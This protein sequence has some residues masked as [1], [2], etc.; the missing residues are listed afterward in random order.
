M[1]AV[2]AD[3]AP[4]VTVRGLDF[5]YASE[6]LLENIQLE[7]P[8]GRIS[9]II[10]PTA[11]GKTTLLQLITGQLRP[12]RGTVLFGGTD[13]HQLRRGELYDLRKRIG[14]QLQRNALLTD[15]SVFD[16]VAFPLREHTP[17][18]ERLIRDIVLMKLEAVGLRGARDQMPAQLSGGMLRRVALARAVA[19]D[20]ELVI[21][22]E[23]FAGQD[24]ITLGVLMR[25]VRTLNDAL[26]LTTIL[27]SHSVDEV[28][29]ICDYVYVISDRRIVAHGTPATVRESASSHVQ[30]F[31]TGAAQGPTAFD[32]PA[33]SMQRDFLRIP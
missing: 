1:T 33:D 15:I 29:A 30:Q 24:P 18:P 23:P 6:L 28:L 12:R 9:A 11:C 8:R 27:V 5:G 31:L 7:I 17:L 16:N 14:M 22:D 19:L 13:V 21:Y 25:L 32:F 3:G 2:M 10:G 20:P 4:L 26:G